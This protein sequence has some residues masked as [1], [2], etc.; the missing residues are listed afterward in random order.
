M[1]VWNKLDGASDCAGFAG[2]S[3]FENYNCG[4]CNS[5]A[6]LKV[7]VLFKYDRY[8]QRLQYTYSKVCKSYIIAI[9]FVNTLFQKFLNNEYKIVVGIRGKHMLNAWRILRNMVTFAIKSLND[10]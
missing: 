1:Q 10:E 6:F 5:N 2:F 7:S 4:T 9:E 8:D 3:L